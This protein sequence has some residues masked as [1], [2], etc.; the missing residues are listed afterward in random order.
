MRDCSA[1]YT[2]RTSDDVKNR[3]R[4]HALYTI[5]TIT[6]SGNNEERQAEILKKVQVA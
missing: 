5:F 3:K 4:A 2:N 1:I 6:M